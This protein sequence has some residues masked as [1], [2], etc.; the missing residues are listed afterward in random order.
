MNPFQP[1]ATIEEVIERLDV[2]INDAIRNK[3][4]A[5]YF[6]ALYRRVTASVKEKI[7]ENY[8]DDNPRMERLDVIFANRYLEAHHNWTNK[9]PCSKSWQLAF[10]ACG[11]WRPMVIQ[12]LFVGMNAHIGLDLG[13]AAAQVQPNDV[14]SLHNDFNKIN[15]ILNHLTDIVQNELAEIFPLMKVVDKLA[16]GSDEKIAGFAMGI[17]RDAAWNV[18][19]DYSKLSPDEHD[20]YISQ[21]DLDVYKFGQK[22]VSPGRWINFVVAIFRILE[23]GNV[24]SKIKILNSGNLG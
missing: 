20:T 15:T 5:G 19:L 23:R 1:A 18:A 24:V 2:I 9:Q 4:R 10:D 12:H 21:R 13:I 6:A 11:Q 8:F 16:G 3:D 14:E 17:A 22:I 7:A